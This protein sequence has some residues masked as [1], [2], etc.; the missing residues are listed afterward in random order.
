MG[1]T[2]GLTFPVKN[3]KPAEN[4]NGGTDGRKDE[5][6]AENQNDRADGRKDEKPA[7]NQNGEKK[8]GIK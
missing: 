2:V 4:K 6:P 1:R 7:E 5:K 3:E 8:P